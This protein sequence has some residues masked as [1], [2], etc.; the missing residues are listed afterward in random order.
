MTTFNHRGYVLKR[1]DGRL[2][3]DSSVS[4]HSRRRA[5]T[6]S[7]LVPVP[8][9][10]GLYVRLTQPEAA[11]LG[12]A[13]RARLFDAARDWAGVSNETPEMHDCVPE[14]D[15]DSELLAV[16]HDTPPASLDAVTLEDLQARA[17]TLAIPGR[18]KMDK[19]ALFEAV[20]AAETTS[21]RSTERG[22]A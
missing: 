18:S 8:D 3:A 5:V 9:A 2:L 20:M 19:A 11:Q 6:H 13:A 12:E 16:N 4:A 15:D 17:R 7:V 22:D 10:P 21:Q 1:P 14:A